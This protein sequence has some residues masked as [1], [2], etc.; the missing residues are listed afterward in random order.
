[1]RL[2]SLLESKR[3]KKIA[4]VIIKRRRPLGWDWSSAY[5]L[6]AANDPVLSL[7]LSSLFL[8]VAGLL[9]LA[10]LPRDEF[11]HRS[12]IDENALMAGLVK[13]EFTSSQAISDLA[14]ELEEVYN[15][16]WVWSGARYKEIYKSFVLQGRANGL[17]WD[18]VCEYWTGGLSSELQCYETCSPT[19][20]GI[21]YQS[22][23]L[24]KPSV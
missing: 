4:A 7:S 20:P 2:A 3:S 1:M 22:A 10:Q 5:E 24:Y 17:A 6:C 11:N 8:Y 13:R 12:F 19:L 9:Y 23:Y 21:M 18:Q 16:R 15:D 14:A